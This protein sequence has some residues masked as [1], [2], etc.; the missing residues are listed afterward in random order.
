MDREINFLWK[1][2]ISNPVIVLQISLL[3]LSARWT[4]RLRRLGIEKYEGIVILFRVFLNSQT[5][6]DG[7]LARCLKSKD[8]SEELYHWLKPYAVKYIWWKTPE[9]ALR[10]PERVVAQVMELGDYNDVQILAK[11][12]GDDY[13]RGVAP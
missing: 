10:Q 1:R 5:P 7:R 11:Q 12:L 9:E 2:Q 4:S 8:L 6:Q 13:L 3:A